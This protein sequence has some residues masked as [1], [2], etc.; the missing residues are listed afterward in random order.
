MYRVHYQGPII[1][2]YVDGDFYGLMANLGASL[3]LNMSIPHPQNPKV[4]GFVVN[5]WD[6]DKVK[7]V[8]HSS[9]K[10]KGTND[11]EKDIATVILEGEQP[12]IEGIERKIAEGVSKRLH[13]A[14]VPGVFEATFIQR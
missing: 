11:I 9:Y 1:D 5:A 8:Y 3:I 14:P 4:I 13:L 10:L 2:Q 6:F 7:V 12:D